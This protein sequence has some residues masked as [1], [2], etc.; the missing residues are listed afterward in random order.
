MCNR[1]PRITEI[2]CSNDFTNWSHFCKVSHILIADFC[3]LPYSSGELQ[4][5]AIRIAEICLRKLSNMLDAFR[6]AIGEGIS[7]ALLLS[8][9][10]SYGDR[11]R[12]VSGGSLRWI[13][14]ARASWVSHVRSRAACTAAMYSASA[15]EWAAVAC[16]ELTQW[17]GPPGKVKTIPVVER[18]ESGHCAQSESQ[19][20]CMDRGTFCVVS[21]E[22]VR[23]RSWV[24]S[25]YRRTRWA[26]AA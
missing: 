5:F 18:R 25:R 11:A 7:S 9:R 17:M 1:V 26:A 23:P 8:I 15:L 13:C 6:R 12:G 20:A 19:N 21:E 2:Y 22:N 14:H 3:N 10:S 4:K 16:L 24:P